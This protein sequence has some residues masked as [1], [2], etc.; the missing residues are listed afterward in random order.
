MWGWLIQQIG[1]AQPHI[2]HLILFIGHL[3]L[4]RASARPVEFFHGG[5]HNEI[6]Q[7]RPWRDVM[8]MA[9]CCCMSMEA[10]TRQTHNPPA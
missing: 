3:N 10:Q 2:L 9:C 4:L 1:F 5:P 6:P 8:G 7:A